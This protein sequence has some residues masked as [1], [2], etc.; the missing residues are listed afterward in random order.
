LTL[1]QTI[2]EPVLPQVIK[3]EAE[4]YHT[5][6]YEQETCLVGN[7]FHISPYE[8]AECEF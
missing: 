5:M 2:K 3:I 8:Y 6:R 7:D 1:K 4:E